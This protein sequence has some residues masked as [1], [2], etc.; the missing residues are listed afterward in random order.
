M[1][2][3][4]KLDQNTKSYK[5][6][7]VHDERIGGFPRLDGTSI[8][9]EWEPL[10]IRYS[11][12]DP[13]VEKEIPNFPSLSGI[14]VCDTQAKDIIFESIKDH[15]EFLPLASHTITDTQYFAIN[16]L[17]VIDCLDHN[18]SEFKRLMSGKIRGI[19]KVDCEKR[20]H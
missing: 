4:W 19:N 20:L 13:V 12:L 11:R 9:K 17:K 15:I 14:L 5:Y 18:F 3:I 6:L 16:A 7:A 2:T 10:Y 8:L 1:K